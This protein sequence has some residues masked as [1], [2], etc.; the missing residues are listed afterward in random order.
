MARTAKPV[1]LQMIR[2]GL[3]RASFSPMTAGTIWLALPIVSQP[4]RS[5]GLSRSRA[6]RESSSARS[7]SIPCQT[8]RRTNL[9]REIRRQRRAENKRARVIH[10]MFFQHRGAADKCSGGA[11]RL[12]AG[13]NRR[14]DFADSERARRDSPSAWAMNARRMRFI[15]NQCRAIFFG[16]RHNFVQ[17]R[18]VSI[19]AEN[20]FR[21]D[22]LSPGRIA[23]FFRARFPTHAGPDADK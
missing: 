6:A 7:W 5:Q 19:H 18:N 4:S 3:E 14:Q 22:Q 2:R 20:R 23:I 12:S 11:Q 21:D 17:R 8:E 10:Q 9:R 13:M 15:D 1:A 16:K